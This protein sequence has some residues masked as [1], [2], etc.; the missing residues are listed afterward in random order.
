MAE[1]EWNVGGSLSDLTATEF[2]VF[3]SDAVWAEVLICL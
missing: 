2:L 3:N 1:D